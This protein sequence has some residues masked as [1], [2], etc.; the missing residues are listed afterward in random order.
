MD[1]VKL[2]NGI[3]VLLWSAMGL[4]FLYRAGS[5]KCRVSVVAAV[6]F[7]AFAGSDAVEIRTGA[8]WRP[9]WLFVWKASCV[10]LLVGLAV[11]QIRMGSKVNKDVPDEA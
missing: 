2:F 4:Y 6:G 11:H 5:Q 3:E 1:F 9:W 7:F 8:W 10:V